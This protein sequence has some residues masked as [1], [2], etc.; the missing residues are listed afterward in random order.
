MLLWHPSPLRNKTFL[1]AETTYFI[2]HL[3]SHYSARVCLQNI[4]WRKGWM[5]RLQAGWQAAWLRVLLT[6][7][8]YIWILTEDMTWS[9]AIK[10]WYWNFKHHETRRAH[11]V[12]RHTFLIPLLLKSIFPENCLSHLI[13]QWALKLRRK[14]NILHLWEQTNLPVPKSNQKKLNIAETWK[15]ND[16]EETRQKHWLPVN[17]LE[18]HLK[19]VSSGIALSRGS[20]T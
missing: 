19:P 13:F 20:T 3:N 4:Y 5:E 18:S 8:W 17:Y 6:C 10:P 16:K 12:G 7:P 9:Q 14:M 2:L 15:P 11:F 1:R